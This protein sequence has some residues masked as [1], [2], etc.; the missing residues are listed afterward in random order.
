M[1]SWQAWDGKIMNKEFLLA[2]SNFRKNRGTSIG[3]F[4]LMLLA[5]LL[6]SLALMITLDIKP[7]AEKEAKRLEAGDGYIVFQTIDEGI[8]EDYMRNLLNDKTRRQQ[9]TE[10][11]YYNFSQSIPL[12]TEL[13]HKL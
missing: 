11:I 10:C 4:L 7:T 5:A 13:F 8:D 9:Y 12:P 1:I 2:K 3:V 6:L